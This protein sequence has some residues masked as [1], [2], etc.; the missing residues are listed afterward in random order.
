MSVMRKSLL[1]TIVIAAAGLGGV[2]LHALADAVLGYT[3]TPMLPSGKWHVHD[4]ARPHPPVVTP[5]ATFSDGAAAPSDA[6]VLFDGTDLSKWEGDKGEPQWIV[7]QDYMEVKPH[8]GYIHTKEKFG[9]FQLHLEFCEPSKVV[10]DSQERGNSGVFLQ[11]VYEVQV[12]D[13]F[14]NPTYAD[15][16]C[17]AIYGQSPPLVNACKKPGQWQTY[18]IFFEAARWN[19]NHELVRPAS[20][21][22]IQNG[23]LLHHKQAILG[24]TGHKILAKYDKELPAE[25]PIALQDHG[26]P[27]RFRN[28]WVR[29][30]QEEEKP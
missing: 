15:G 24:P 18:D 5:G 6:I 22:V 26:N 23:L 17:G 2:V 4:P 27:M 3:D 7:H 9:D 29:K 30:I 8:S 12:L 28:I 10:G 16:Q 21:T 25:A 11:G 1:I 14:N 19:E 13:C 20:V